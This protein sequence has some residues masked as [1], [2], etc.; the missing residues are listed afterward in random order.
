M[1]AEVVRANQKQRKRQREKHRETETE[2]ETERMRA[3][4]T[5]QLRYTVTDRPG[6]AIEIV[7]AA[8][9]FLEEW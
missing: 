8:D 6:D 2:T 5:Y 3:R 1:K 4:Q 9:Q 7:A